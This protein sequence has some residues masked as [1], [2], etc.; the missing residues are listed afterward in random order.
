[1][2]V[3]S[4]EDVKKQKTKINKN[5]Q[6]NKQTKTKQKPIFQEGKEGRREGKKKMHCTQHTAG[7]GN[8]QGSH[9]VLGNS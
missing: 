2:G 9:C 8:R 4:G 5:K 1:M 7:P 3:G 6:T